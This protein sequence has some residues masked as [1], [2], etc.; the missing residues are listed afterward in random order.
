M[1]KWKK[2]NIRLTSK[3]ILRKHNSRENNFA[4][5]IL[6]IYLCLYLFHV[7]W[8]GSLILSFFY[9]AEQTKRIL[10]LFLFIYILFNFF[11]FFFLY[12]KQTI[13]IQGTCQVQNIP[14]GP[15]SIV[16]G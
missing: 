8:S 2:I 9:Q 5:L 11:S 7:T 15:S 10:L 16:D 12:S 4:F 13:E 3:I 1:K 14:L 6:F